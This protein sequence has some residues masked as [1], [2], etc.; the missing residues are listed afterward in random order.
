MERWG[1]G[2]GAGLEGGAPLTLVCEFERCRDALLGL[3]ARGAW[4]PLRLSMERDGRLSAEI[5][6]RL[7]AGMD[8]LLSADIDGRLSVEMEG[9]L[10]PAGDTVGVREY[11]G[12]GSGLASSLSLLALFAC[13]LALDSMDALVLGRGIDAPAMALFRASS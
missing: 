6:G 13:T 3:L 1:T 2:I 8:G 9:R 10:L 11:V 4:D 7:S 12:R 5:D